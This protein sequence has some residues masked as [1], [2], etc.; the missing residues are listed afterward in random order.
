[1][2]HSSDDDS[3]TVL[4]SEIAMEASGSVVDVIR[5]PFTKKPKSFSASEGED[6]SKWLLSYESCAKC[7]QWSDSDML[8]KLPIFLDGYALSVYS[9]EIEP[10]KA[11]EWKHVRQLFFKLFGGLSDGG[12]V[13]TFTSRKQA[14]GE[15]ALKYILDMQALA[16]QDDKAF[17][18]ELIFQVIKEGLRPEVRNAIKLHKPSD[19]ATLKELCI[20]FEGPTLNDASGFTIPASQSGTSAELRE[21]RE[22]IR[23]LKSEI[24]D[25]NVKVN[26]IF[27]TPVQQ[28]QY[29]QSDVQVGYWNPPPM[30]PPWQHG[31]RQGRGG[32]MS[33]AQYQP[34]HPPWH[35]QF[36]QQGQACFQ[37]PYG[38]APVGQNYPRYQAPRTS[39]AGYGQNQTPVYINQ[40]QQLSSSGHQQQPYGQQEH[41]VQGQQQN[42]FQ[43]PN[44]AQYQGTGFNRGGQ[45]RRQF[46]RFRTPDGVVICHRCHEA[47]HYKSNC[48]YNNINAMADIAPSSGYFD[49]E[50]NAARALPAPATAPAI[51]AGP[52]AQNAVKSPQVNYLGVYESLG[53]S[54]SDLSFSTP[55]STDALSGQPENVDILFCS[56]SLHATGQSDM[57]I[58]VKVNGFKT[59][60]LCDSGADATLVSARRVD[61]NLVDKDIN[62]TCSSA[63][64]QQETALGKLDVELEIF[65]AGKAKSNKIRAIVA[66]NIPYDVIIGKDSLSTFG[67]DLKF[68]KAGA[69]LNM[70]SDSDEPDD[71][72]V[73]V[74]ASGPSRL[75]QASGF[76]KNFGL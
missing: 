32:Y 15:P 6:V 20:E 5:F 48:P 64:G 59:F 54:P 55:R 43:H 52:S 26:A 65:V 44:I 12:Y 35:Q 18:D 76:L 69:Q 1:M 21:L 45:G 67:L 57:L 51:T 7:N 11:L 36:Q 8:K 60:G 50:A 37:A 42:R 40:Q 3:K 23:A 74:E 29:Q 66:E 62:V 16:S 27:E 22:E 49:H 58:P 17:S 63:F 25:K 28:P 24:K 72:L 70:T 41:Q 38:Q 30:R 9:Y 33:Q 10:D 71:I 73:D 34:R 2:P 68:R 19:L 47:G 61:I 53:M 56:D 75:L 4:K 46:N 39:N 14:R 13:G 31:N